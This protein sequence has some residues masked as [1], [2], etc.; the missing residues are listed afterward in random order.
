MRDESLLATLRTHLRPGVMNQIIAQGWTNR[1]TLMD[2]RG[3][4]RTS[5]IRGAGPLARTIINRILDGETEGLV[6]RG[7][8]R[9][10][11]FE[12]RDSDE[13][14]ARDLL[15][16]MLPLA[17]LW[18]MVAGIYV[19]KFLGEIVYVGKSQNVAERVPQHI[20][21]KEFDSAE[22]A[23]L[24]GSVIA[25]PRAEIERIDSELLAKEKALIRFLRPKLNRST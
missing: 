23:P 6:P 10:M 13:V 21:S 16:Q 5:C 18:K 11:N 20:I 14:V 19:L 2:A 25:L 3:C 24:F 15:R 17:G 12:L 4:G 9:R 22:Y 1:A 7:Q 8:P